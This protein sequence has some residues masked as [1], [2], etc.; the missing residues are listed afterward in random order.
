ML[1][2]KYRREDIPQ[3]FFYTGYQTDKDR[4]D[5]TP[6]MLWI[7]N[8]KGEDG[9]HRSPQQPIPECL[10]YDDWKTDKDDWDQTPLM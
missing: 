3:E 1:W 10:Y 6:L 7:E 8:R 5:R 9:D 2:I 4:F